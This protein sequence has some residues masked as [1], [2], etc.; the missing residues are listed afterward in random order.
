MPGRPV[1]ALS[2]A[3]TLSNGSQQADTR[4]THRHTFFTDASK[5]TH[6]PTHSRPTPTHPCTLIKGYTHAHLVIRLSISARGVSPLQRA[7]AY[8]AHA[9]P[10]AAQ[11]GVREFLLLLLLLAGGAGCQGWGGTRGRGV[12]KPLGGAPG[13]PGTA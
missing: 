9:Q 2:G 7:Y 10:S 3:K 1:H 11:R 6:T 5:L 12:S 4:T 13:A 8:P